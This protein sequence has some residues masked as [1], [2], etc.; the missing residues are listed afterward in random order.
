M[1]SHPHITA[2]ATRVRRL[3]ENWKAGLPPHSVTFELPQGGLGWR[4][5]AGRGQNVHFLFNESA[6][7]W[8]FDETQGYRATARRFGPWD[9][10]IMVAVQF[11]NDPD[12][13]HFKLR[14]L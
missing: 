6:S 8:L 11:K 13:V 12:A 5:S 4:I 1:I 9:S 3:K 10:E 14:W 2:R 7:E